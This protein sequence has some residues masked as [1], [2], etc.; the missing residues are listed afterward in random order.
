MAEKGDL[1]LCPV[2][3]ASNREG[4]HPFSIVNSSAV[5]SSPKDKGISWLIQTQKL[6]MPSKEKSVPNLSS[7]KALYLR[8]YEYWLYLIHTITLGN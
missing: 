2:R 5:I 6:C 7:D 8:P 4:T 1:L 3:P